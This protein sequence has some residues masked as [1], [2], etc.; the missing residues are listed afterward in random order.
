MLLVNCTKFIK[1]ISNMFSQIMVYAKW[2]IVTSRSW[3]RSR[4]ETFEKLELL[5]SPIPY[6]SSHEVFK[7]YFKMMQMQ[8]MAGGWTKRWKIDEYFIYRGMKNLWENWYPQ[9]TLTW[10][11]FHF[12][13]THRNVD[14]WWFMNTVK[15]LIFWCCC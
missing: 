14:K 11:F 15:I 2:G 12:R 4:S 9:L 10:H 5:W 3:E 7:K 13:N 8:G 1:K 6:I